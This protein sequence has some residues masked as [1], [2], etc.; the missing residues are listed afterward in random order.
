MTIEDRELVER[1]LFSLAKGLDFADALH[2]SSYHQCESLASFD[3]KKFA[4]RSN[5]LALI[6]RVIVPK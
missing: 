2:H 5:K 3:E 4:R 6:P 1:A